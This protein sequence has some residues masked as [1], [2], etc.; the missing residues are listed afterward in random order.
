MDTQNLRAF[1]AVAEQASFSGA[2]SQL[3]LT[4]PAVS[5]RIATLEQQLGCRLFDRIGRRVSLTE[6][7]RAL[8]PKARR[9]LQEV[10][11][12]RR[13]IADLAGSVSGRLVLATSHHIGLHRLPAVLRRFTRRYPAVSLD[14]DF[15]DSEKACEA[16]LQGQFELAIITLGPAHENLLVSHTIWVD[17]LVF[18]CAPDHPLQS[19]TAVSL[20]DLSQYPAILPD[21]STYTTALIKNRF[22]A[23]EVPLNLTMAT[24]YLETIKMMVSIGLGW[25]VLPVT[26]VDRQLAPLKLEGLTR[27]LGCVYHRERTLSNAATAFLQ[28]LQDPPPPAK[29]GT[30]VIM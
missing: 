28:S 25:S 24:N 23:Q 11:D 19:R 1:R 14:L 10:T 26:I 20:A 13:L 7:G 5:K 6:A 22:D 16:V 8:L 17:P 2:A 4:Q 29:A 21:M 15:L 27:Q 12:A 9:I 30:G 3:H 18:V